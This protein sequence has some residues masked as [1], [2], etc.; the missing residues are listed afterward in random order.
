MLSV[1]CFSKD[2]PLQMEAYLE[3]L[4]YFGGLK[5]ERI[6]ILVACSPGISYDLLIERHPRVNWV[7]EASFHDDLLAALRVSENYVLLGCDDVVFKDFFD[8][9]DCI[10]MLQTRQDV[11][12]F[13]LRLGANLSFLPALHEDDGI[14]LWDWQKAK[15]DYWRYPWEVSASIYHRDFILRYL[16]ARPDITNPNRF[17]AFLAKQIDDLETQTPPKLACFPKSCCAT[18]TVNRVQ[19]EY[20]N[21]FDESKDTSPEKL[22]R[23][24]VNRLKQDWFKLAHWNN[25]S[26]HVGAEN[27]ELVQRIE[28]PAAVYAL[29]SDEKASVRS[30]RVGLALKILWWRL[31]T[32]LWEE[33]RKRLPRK[34]LNVLKSIVRYV[35]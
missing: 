30:R 26:V 9:N 10:K 2:R 35:S 16:E 13:S 31:V 29:V 4:M 25:D 8:S 18:I 28:L 12:G 21:E 7:H 3:S 17:E 5:P 34:A 22:Y 11:F 23:D 15:G 32:V 6:T 24:H 33:A 14:F 19:D 27:F 20:P 1:I